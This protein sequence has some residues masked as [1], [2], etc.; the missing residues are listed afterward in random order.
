MTASTD[1][2]DDDLASVLAAC[3]EALADGSLPPIQT[4]ESLSPEQSRLL[5]GL[6]CIRMMRDVW[7]RP[8]PTLDGPGRAP[9]SPV[10]NTRLFSPSTI[11]RFQIVKEI[12]RGGFGVVFLAF[13]PQVGRSIALKVPRPDMHLT[14]QLRDR[15]RHE[16][17]AAGALDHPNIVPVYEAGEADDLT[18][19]AT[20]YCPGATLAKWIE[21]RKQP[22]PVRLAADMVACLADGVTHA[23][24]RNVLHRDLKPA[25]V[26][27]WSPE[28]S[29]SGPASDFTPKI[30]DFGLAKSFVLGEDSDMTASG[31][32]V[33]TP[34]YLA[35]EQAGGKLGHVGP[36][37]DVYGLGAILYELLVRRPPF[38][39]ENTLQTL[40]QVRFQE[41]VSPRRLRPQIPRDLETICLKCLQKNPARRYANPSALATDLRLFL[42]GKPIHARPTSA[43][44]RA[45]RLARRN[46]L[47]SGLLVALLLAITIGVVG[48][49]DQWRRAENGAKQAR[50]D[51]DVALGAR[52]A[53]ANAKNRALENVRRARRA[54]EQM[55]KAGM[56]LY[57]QP[58]QQE[59][60]RQIIEQA[61]E[62]HEG[63]VA[64]QSDDRDVIIDAARAFSQVGVCRERLGQYDEAIAAERRSI[65]LYDIAISRGPGDAI[66]FERARNLRRLASYLTLMDRNMEATEAYESAIAEFRRFCSKS[67]DDIGNRIQL[68]NTLMNLGVELVNE[69][70]NRAEALYSEALAEDAQALAADPANRGIL[71][72]QGLAEQ[73]LGWL[74]WKRDRSSRG[75][76]LIGDSREIFRR[77]VAKEPKNVEF[78][79]FLARSHRMVARVACEDGRFSPAATAYEEAR[80]AFESLKRDFPSVVRYTVQ[81]LETE[82]DI[83]TLWEQTG[84]SGDAEKSYRKLIVSMQS[85]KTS[86][87]GKQL[88]FRYGLANSHIRLWRLL[89]SEGKVEDAAQFVER[90]E[91]SK[92]IPAFVCSSLARV[93]V[94]G[95]D[96][97]RR[98]CQG[99]LRLAHR[100]VE[101]EPNQVEHWLAMAEVRLRVN[102]A[103]NAMDALSKAAELQKD[104]SVEIG[105]LRA[106]SSHQLSDT[107][108][109]HRYFTEAQ[110]WLDA[111]GT[112]DPDV[113]R[114]L[115]EA[116]EIIPGMGSR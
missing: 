22:I 62:F 102:D 26:M 65:E 58:G 1:H 43:A 71:I 32:I 24:A 56:D 4:N 113:Q 92:D 89:I 112:I 108:A 76:E 41:P 86:D 69:S 10:R 9:D 73:A 67:P 88:Q 33:G 3:D 110:V 16:A 23:H 15:F 11:G 104:Y 52:T 61:V 12:G 98:D 37:T 50:G 28:A 54:V 82:V 53:E 111:N 115:S 96:P 55:T 109:A 48:V 17:Q 18:Y 85:M 14:P 45:V 46:P 80:L 74:L 75:A 6:E 95:Q 5:K 97:A 72:E 39:G 8:S 2:S 77:L 116:R 79:W 100:A 66:E 19:I 78:R 20:A 44:E 29:E 87:S 114:L 59:L 105:L 57:R 64:D 35:P 90:I 91:R 101:S 93:M 84:R 103:K 94:G 21:G 42:E 83:G 63:F 106:L 25:N 13:D 68:V 47:A 60:G 40:D 30:T 107:L 49:L 81:A 36:A 34:S 38:D 7:R 31:A 27:L 51:R 70:P 99:A